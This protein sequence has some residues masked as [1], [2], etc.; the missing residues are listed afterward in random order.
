M[1]KC[2]VCG[3][4]MLTADGCSVKD[5][6]INDKVFKRIKY[7]SEEDFSGIH[8]AI[9]NKRCPDC[10]ALPGNYHHFGCDIERCP[11]CGEQLLSCLCG[12][13]YVEY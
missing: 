2:K 5:V 12:D 1:A 8:F 9:Q 13:V 4:E 7:G 3:K 11:K 6:H 10:G